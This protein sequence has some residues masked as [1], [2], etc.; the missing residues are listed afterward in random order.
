MLDKSVPFIPFTMFRPSDAPPLPEIQLPKDYRIVFYQPGDEKEWCK[1]ETAVLEF[2]T[3]KD[4]MDYFQ[5][6]FAP[7]QDELKK[8]CSLL[9]MPKGKRWGPL[10][11]GGQMIILRVFIG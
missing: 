10:L 4:A 6:S 5:R 2:E 7:Y 1:I 11:L 8:G 9:K 3:E